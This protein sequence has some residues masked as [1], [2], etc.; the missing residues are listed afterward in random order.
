VI[1]LAR[2]GQTDFYVIDGIQIV[3]PENVSVLKPLRTPSLTLVTCFP[4]YFVGSA[5]QRYV[6][7]ASLRNSSQSRETA[8]KD[9][10]STGNKT[11][12]QGE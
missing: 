10:I 12:P 3:C 7:R 6:V 2:P 11:K 1:E 8:S 4:F 9:W 5:P